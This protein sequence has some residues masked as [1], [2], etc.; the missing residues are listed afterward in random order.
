MCVF[1]LIFFF[2]CAGSHCSR[3]SEQGLLSG[4]AVWAFDCGGFFCGGVQ[5]L[6]H[7]GFSSYSAWAQ[8]LWCLSLVAL[9]DWDLHEQESNPRL[10][11]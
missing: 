10:L 2:G 1:F 6:G 8:Q 7:G 4:C 5:A 11:H 9:G 3:C